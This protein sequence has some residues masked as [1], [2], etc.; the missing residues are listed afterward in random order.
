M[1]IYLQIFQIL[2]LINLSNIFF[3]ILLF[4]KAPTELKLRTLQKSNKNILYKITHP[5]GCRDLMQ[6]IGWVVNSDSYTL[7][8][9]IPLRMLYMFC[10]KQV[11]LRLI[12]RLIYN[13]PILFLNI[14]PN[15]FLKLL[16]FCTNF[17]INQMIY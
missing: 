3:F 4:L 16:T 13:F 10:D 7:P 17:N 9:T 2:N 15:K 14:N 12:E 6:A 11:I 5:S 1:Y 8:N